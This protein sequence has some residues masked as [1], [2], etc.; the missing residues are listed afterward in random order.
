MAIAQLVGQA[1]AL[2]HQPVADPLLAPVGGDADG[3]E[4]Q[5]RRPGRRAGDGDRPLPDGADHPAPV[6]RDQSKAASTGAD[7]LAEAVGLLLVAVGP[8]GLVEQGLDGGEL[9][10]ALRPRSRRGKWGWARQAG[11]REHCWAWKVPWQAR[12]R[13][14]RR[15]TFDAY[16]GAKG[17]FGQTA[18]AAGKI[19]AEPARRRSR[20]T[21]VTFIPLA[22]GA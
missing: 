15:G 19:P 16:G 17:R 2:A 1:Q 10:W 4:Q 8:E 6:A 12:R 20:R 21:V 18:R 22:Q 9:S 14:D 5:S 3:A 13:S 11:A 7:M